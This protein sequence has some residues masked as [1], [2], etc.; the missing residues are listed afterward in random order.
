[1]NPTTRKQRFFQ[2]NDDD[3]VWCVPERPEPCEKSA[4]GER[5][6]ALRRQGVREEGP[7]ER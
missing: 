4:R 7:C 6:G 5:E 3:V 2:G 1:M